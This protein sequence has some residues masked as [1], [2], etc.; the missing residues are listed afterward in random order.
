MSTLDPRVQTVLDEHPEIAE[1][2]REVDRSLLRWSLALDPFERLRILNQRARS[3]ARFEHV[4]P[5]NR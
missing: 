1:L 2:V 3:L 5:E 4:A